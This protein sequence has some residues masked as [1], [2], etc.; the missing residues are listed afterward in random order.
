MMMLTMLE[1]QRNIVDEMS[2]LCGQR[3]V[4]VDYIIALGREVEALPVAEQVDSCLVMGCLSKVW[5]VPTYR[6]GVLLLRGYSDALITRGLLALLL[7]VFSGQRSALI[8]SELIFFVEAIGLDR[9]ISTQ[10]RGGLHAMI[11]HI[12]ILARSI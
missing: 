4:M 12:K 7:R 8:V 9:V 3:D 2:I 1:I 5:I 10:R 11:D 6:D